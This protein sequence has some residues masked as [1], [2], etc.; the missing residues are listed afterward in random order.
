MYELYMLGQAWAKFCSKGIEPAFNNPI[1]DWY[2]N[3][4]TESM[5]S[6]WFWPGQMVILE[7][8]TKEFMKIFG[9]GNICCPR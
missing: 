6:L 7:D 3:Q 2:M 8:Q 9:A 1:F 5:L 4:M